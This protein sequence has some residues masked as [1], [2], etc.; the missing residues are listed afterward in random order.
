M[1]GH[2]R[3]SRDSVVLATFAVLRRLAKM[4][5]ESGSPIVASRRELAMRIGLSSYRVSAAL[6]RLEAAGLIERDEAVE[7][8]SG[9][10]A[11]AYSVTEHG[12]AL[13]RGI[14]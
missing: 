14:G 6:D 5:E 2:G 9:R 8:G 12:H 13:V 4:E 11:R 3:T 1:G 7:D 10:F